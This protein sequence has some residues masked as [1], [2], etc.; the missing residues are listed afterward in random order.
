MIT[1]SMGAVSFGLFIAAVLGTLALGAGYVLALLLK[2][3]VWAR[4]ILRIELAGLALYAALFLLASLTSGNR[5][6]A[7]GEEKHICEVDCHLAYA[8][9]GTRTARQWDGK[10]AQGTFYVVTVRVRFDS[11][12]IAPWRPRNAPL[13]PNG[14][15]VAL[16][17][18]RGRRYPAA[19]D[20]LHR[21]L[22]PGQEYSA[23]FVF[24]LPADAANP[25]LML[26]SSDWP[27]HLMIAHENAFLH[28]KVL[29]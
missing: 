2:R 4:W 16:V 3:A 29:F 26:T 20:A 27:T 17:D 18:D 9:M 21:Q 23:D 10:T 15:I 6:L 1:D 28:G 13:S 7:V 11:G 5:E 24:D 12:T 19:V 8:V 14:R 25:R 22:L